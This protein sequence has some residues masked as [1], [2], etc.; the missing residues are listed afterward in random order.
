MPVCQQA[1]GEPI[2]PSQHGHT[3]R[4]LATTAEQT[5]DGIGGSDQCD[6]GNQRESISPDVQTIHATQSAETN[7]SS[8]RSDASEPS[9]NALQV[10]ES[11]VN[12]TLQ[13][14]D[15]ALRT[16]V[17]LREPLH[18]NVNASTS[19]LDIG[20]GAGGANF[21]ET[22]QSTNAAEQ[23]ALLSDNTE[24][25]AHSGCVFESAHSIS[26]NSQSL[27]GTDATGGLDLRQS[28]GRFQI[29]QEPPPFPTGRR[30]TGTPSL[31]QLRDR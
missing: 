7:G 4:P 1:R 5:R 12:A 21:Q 31:S 6:I 3:L 18:D 14:G 8:P 23:V 17:I 29:S 30:T 9:V 24:R 10:Q 19:S 13:Q 22:L 2:T 15:P 28:D 20:P 25:A 27:T 11:W 26:T 16:L